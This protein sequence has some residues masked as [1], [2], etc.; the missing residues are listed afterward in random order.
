MKN[1]VLFLTLFIAFGSISAN[2]QSLKNTLQRLNKTSSSEGIANTETTTTN[3]DGSSSS[4]LSSLT[5]EQAND[6]IKE[7]LIQGVVEGVT[8][9]SQKDGYF[10][11]NLVKIGFPEEIKKVESTLR[12]VGLDKMVDKGVQILNHA[13]EDAVLS[14]TDIFV[15]TIKEMTLQ[16]AIGIVAGDDKAATEYL[17]NHT[18]TKLLEKLSPNIKESLDKVGAPKYWN[19]IITRYNQMPFAQNQVEPDLTKYVTQKTIDGL[20]TKI[21][22]KEKQIRQDPIAR[23]SDILKSVFGN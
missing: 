8:Q 6:G 4:S 9:L 20:F 18:S 19:N 2:A 17:K 15:N 23:T 7:A 16:D 13:A 5:Q 21:A 22:T 12:A 10:G 3:N 11:D 14:A 1:I